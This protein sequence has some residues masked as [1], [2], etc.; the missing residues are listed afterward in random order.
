MEVTATVL[1]CFNPQGLV[2]V[3]IALHFSAFGSGVP[4]GSIWG[5]LFFFFA[6]HTTIAQ[7][8]VNGLHF[9]FAAHFFQVS[10]SPAITRWR[11][12]RGC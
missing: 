11:L 9:C 6:V 7:Q 2:F 12:P 10:L 5:P 4:Q 1:T 8:Q 3:F